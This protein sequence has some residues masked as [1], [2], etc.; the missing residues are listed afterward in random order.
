[1]LPLFQ[2]TSCRVFPF[3]PRPPTEPPRGSPATGVGRPGDFSLPEGP[4]LAPHQQAYLSSLCVEKDEPEGKEEELALLS[5][6]PLFHLQKSKPTSFHCSFSL[7]H[8]SVLLRFQAK[9]PETLLSALTSTPGLWA[10]ALSPPCHHP[11][12][13]PLSPQCAAALPHPAEAA[14]PPGHQEDWHLYCELP[15]LLC[16]VCR[17]QVGPESGSCRGNSWEGL[18]SVE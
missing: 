8:P 7:P 1:M 17:D 15:H 3:C 2:I 6:L 9:H 14:P 11:D 13:C 10:W 4:S 18:A 5:R 16:P 12:H